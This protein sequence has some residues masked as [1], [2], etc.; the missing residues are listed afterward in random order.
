MWALTTL[1]IHKT[2]GLIDLPIRCS[3]INARLKILYVEKTLFTAAI[4]GYTVTKGN[5]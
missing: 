1:T 3:A 2:Y 5:D 4:M